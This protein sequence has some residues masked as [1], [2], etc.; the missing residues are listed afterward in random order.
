[1][2]RDRFGSVQGHN[3]FLRTMPDYWRLER[4]TRNVGM[5]ITAL[6]GLA[7]LVLWLVMR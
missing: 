4:D 1:M 5:P 2:I 6:I 7:L 3:H